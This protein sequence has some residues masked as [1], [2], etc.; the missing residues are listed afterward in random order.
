MA[1]KRIGVLTGGGDAPGLNAAIRAIVRK[2]LK[3]G[4]EVYGI[5][6]GWL[7]LIDGDIE[8][9]DLD[10]ISGILH[11]GGTFLGTSRTN[12]YKKEGGVKKVLDNIEK[13]K[14]DCLITLGGEDTNSVSNKLYGEGVKCVGVPKTI[15]NDISGT[16]YT[17]GFDTALSIATD[18]IDN[19]HSTAVSHHRVMVVEVMGRNTGWIAILAGLAGG[20]DVIL[21]PEFEFDFDEIINR[22]EKRKNRGK[23]FSI[24]VVAEGAKPSPE[25][26]QIIKSKEVDEF[27][28]VML[29]GM[30]KIIRNRL[31]EAGY[32]TR[33][34]ILGHL[35]RGG[36]PT[37]F[38][39]I[40]AL[41][42]GAVAVDLVKEEKFN[43]MVVLRGTKIMDIPIEEAV[44]QIK[45]VD[46]ELYEL[47]KLFY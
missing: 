17:I 9:L 19:L 33:D 46:K 3:Y 29:G 45:Y 18:A 5:K 15:D 39:R 32:E 13:F 26:E 4:Y 2:A 8:K 25:A 43:R 24:V 22:I 12:P 21:I 20:A 14:L 1:I 41:K 6:N 44:K 40:L 37:A 42:L 28:H 38:D 27:G 34:V 30:G 16:D 47:S 10:S 31:K 35:Q 36:K 11:V 23:N 7:G